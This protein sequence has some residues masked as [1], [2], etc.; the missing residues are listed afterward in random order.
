M[1]PVYDKAEVNYRPGSPEASCATCRYFDGQSACQLVQGDIRPDGVSDL[2]ES[3]GGGLDQLAGQM[4]M[5]G[6]SPGMM[7]LA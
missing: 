6:M 2:Y 5:P 4:Q 3:G 1:P 7:G